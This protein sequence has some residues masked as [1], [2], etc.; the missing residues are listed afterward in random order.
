MQNLKDA[1]ANPVAW[2]RINNS[3]DLYDLR[4]QNNPYNNQEKI[5]PLYTYRINNDNN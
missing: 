3:G 2:A 4:L 1:L 5:V